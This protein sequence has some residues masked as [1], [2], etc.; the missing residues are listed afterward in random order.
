MRLMVKSWIKNRFLFSS[1]LIVLLA[2]VLPLV[3]VN[4]YVRAK[5]ENRERI[6]V[7]KESQ[8]DYDIPQPTKTQL[9]EISAL[10]FVN[11]TFGYYYS[12]TT[13]THNGKQQTAK[14]LFSDCMDSLEMTMYC[15]S[16]L[17]SKSSVLY[18]N[19]IYFDYETAK[20][21]NVSVGDQV[22][23]SG[24]AFTVQAIYETNVYYDGGA[25]LVPLIGTQKELIESNATSYSGAYLSVNDRSKAESFFRTYKPEGR[26]KSRDLFDSDEEYQTHYNAWNSASYYIEITSFQEKADS[27]LLKEATIP[28]FAIILYAVLLIVFDVFLTI[29][30]R[31]IGIFKEKEYGRDIPYYYLLASAFEITIACVAYI[32]TVI[33]AVGRI[34]VYVDP[35]LVVTAFVGGV[36][37]AVATSVLSGTVDY[38]I[39]KSHRKKKE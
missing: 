3:F 4:P 20:K 6:G 16:R 34:D 35:S 12:K 21:G 25:I 30:K 22:V 32:F 2:I 15:S 14:V 29:R 11:E 18:D 38:A 31:E 27:V 7:Y 23:L 19:P 24:I 37:C 13:F 28:V 5:A 39:V 33:I 36:A 1:I 10:D 26:L 17:I 9:D 8:I